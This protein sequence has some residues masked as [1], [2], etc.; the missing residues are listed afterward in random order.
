MTTST[1]PS[2]FSEEKANPEQTLGAS[3][4]TSQCFTVQPQEI[5]PKLLRGELGVSLKVLLKHHQTS[6]EQQ[7]V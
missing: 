7:S 6:A 2:D 4:C 3:H 1:E 5:G